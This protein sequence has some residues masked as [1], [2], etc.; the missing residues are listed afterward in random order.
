VS[1]AAPDPPR[2]DENRKGSIEPRKLADLIVLDRDLLEVPDEQIPDT[3]VVLTVISGKVV[4][5]RGQL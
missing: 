2:H 4:Y 3:N 1:S 5:R